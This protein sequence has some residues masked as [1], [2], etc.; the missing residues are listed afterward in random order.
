MATKSKHVP[1]FKHGYVSDGDN[2]NI[3]DF[4]EA[5]AKLAKCEACGCDATL[6][7][8]TMIDAATGAMQGVYIENGE[9]VIEPIA[10]AIANLEALCAAR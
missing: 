6:G 5:L 8:W 10:T 2:Q 9:L 3:A 4:Q 1:R 7:L